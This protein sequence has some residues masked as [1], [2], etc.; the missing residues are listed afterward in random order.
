MRFLRSYK[1]I[2]SETKDTTLEQSESIPT[3]LISTNLMSKFYRK[4]LITE[5][6]ETL[7]EN[8]AWAPKNEIIGLFR[9]LKINVE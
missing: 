7:Y 3:A 8:E 1:E 5:G 4:T 2:P 9:K 6:P